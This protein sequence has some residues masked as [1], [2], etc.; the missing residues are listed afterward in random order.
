MNKSDTGSDRI[1]S[2]SINRQNSMG[3]RVMEPLSGPT[4]EFYFFIW[5]LIS[6]YPN[7]R[8]QSW[9]YDDLPSDSESRIQWNPTLILY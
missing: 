4:G 3:F 7:S 5:V 2:Y 6:I 8:E 9:Y 1:W